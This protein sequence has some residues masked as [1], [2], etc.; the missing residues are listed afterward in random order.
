MPAIQKHCQ[1]CHERLINKRADTRHCSSSCRSKSWRAEQDKTT[2]V[3]VA[4]SSTQFK[5][6]KA[7]ADELGLLVNQF[8]VL[9]AT[10]TTI[11]THRGI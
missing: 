10:N 6:V 11:N 2:S 4:L 5:Q 8:I 3:K 9:R 1:H 7:D